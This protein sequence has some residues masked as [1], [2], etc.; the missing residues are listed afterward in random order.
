V[1]VYV[2]ALATLSAISGAAFAQSSVTLSGRLNVGMTSLKTSNTSGA[3]VAA[4]S[5]TVRDLTGAENTKTGSR[6]TA[7]GVEDLGGGLKAGFDFTAAL[8]PTE[9]GGAMSTRRANVS[10]MGGFGTVAM[11]SF[12][13]NA[14]DAV[15]AFSP[16]V[17]GAAGGDYQARLATGATLLDYGTAAFGTALAAGTDLGLKDA[18]GANRAVTAADLTTGFAG[19]ASNAI[20]YALPAMGDLKASV[21]MVSQKNVVANTKTDAYLLGVE[22]AAGDLAVK[23]GYGSGKQAAVST[24][25]AA[26]VSDL[27]LGASYNLGMAVPYITY[28][29]AKQSGAGATVDG[30]K[31]TGL[32]LGAKFPMGALTPYIAIGTGSAKSDAKFA[33][34]TAYQLG[35]NYDLSKRTSVYV[36]LGQ[37]KVKGSQAGDATVSKR[38]GYSA[39]VVHMF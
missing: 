17:S 23:A 20:V 33:K 9:R 11:G 14:L 28:E 6:L 19:N 21:S 7:S 39:G 22:Y 10:L 15:R 13:T 2:D 38:T 34:S 25:V 1:F 35:A 37:D 18:N 36:T 26:K 29:S 5:T 24:G 3:G 8:S 4:A 31:T 12:D 30:L 32:E 27:A 16:T